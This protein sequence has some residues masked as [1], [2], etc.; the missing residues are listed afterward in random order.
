MLL[1]SDANVNVLDSRDRS[2]LDIALAVEPKE[3]PF[4]G[5]S[6]PVPESELKAVL[7][8]HD[9]KT[10]AELKAEKEHENGKE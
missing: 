8:K 1:E 9:A 7:R 6:L 10:G 5:E 3:N 2:A 4:G